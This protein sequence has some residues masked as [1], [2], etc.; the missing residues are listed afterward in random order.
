MSEKVKEVAKEEFEQAKVLAA[1]A[2]RSQAY[3]YPLKACS[4]PKHP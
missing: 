4:T 3:L 2:V 1:G